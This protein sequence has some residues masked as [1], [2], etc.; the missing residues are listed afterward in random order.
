M[1]GGDAHDDQRRARA[2]VDYLEGRTLEIDPRGLIC[3]VSTPLARSAG[4]EP[5]ELLGRPAEYLVHPDDATAL[6]DALTGA[7][8]GSPRAYEARHRD[9]AGA[10]HWLSVRLLP[11]VDDGEI[12]GVLAVTRDISDLVRSRSDLARSAERF[13]LAM[14]YAPIGMAVVDLDRRFVE[15][16]PALARITGRSPQ[17]LLAHR[18]PD[19]ID[20]EHDATD[21]ALHARVLA[22]LEEEGA[23]VVRL[24]KDDGSQVVVEHSVAVLRDDQ[25]RPL[26]YVAQFVDIT[27]T[28]EAQERLRFLALHDELTS[29]ANRRALTEQL[30]VT[31]SRPRSADARVALL[32]IDLDGFKEANDTWGHAAGD[33]LLVEVARRLRECA[34]PSA[35]VA[36]LGGDEFVVGLPDL[37]GPQPA[38]ALAARI[39]ERIEHPVVVGDRHIVVRASIGIAVT[40]G[41]GGTDQLLREADLALYEA[42]RSGR[43]RASRYRASAED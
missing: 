3:W 15:V 39:L 42:K 20:T 2:L 13:R 5:A 26:S 24:I 31:L 21:I 14:E 11:V 25:G 8:S 12:G 35:I 28:V 34:P 38:E 18:V 29:L 4:W 36:R 27:A 1:G 41:V 19:I 16:N 30:D 33:D 17:W 32:F 7:W 23:T 10:Y 43:G 22:G 37:N 40:D 9:R 6:Q